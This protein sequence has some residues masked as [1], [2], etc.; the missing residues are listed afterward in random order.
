MV[1]GYTQLLSSNIYKMTKSTEL[2]KWRT[3]LRKYFFV[4]NA[5]RN[6]N[7]KAPPMN[8]QFCTERCVST[9][10]PKSVQFVQGGEEYITYFPGRDPHRSE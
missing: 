1:K 3:D 10:K 8:Y 9:R 6:D 4:K 5:K 2:C 7:L